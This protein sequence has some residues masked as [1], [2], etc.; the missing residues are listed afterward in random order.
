MSKGKPVIGW[1]QSVLLVLGLFSYALIKNFYFEP[2]E[3]QNNG[4]I[5]NLFKQKSQGKMV[6]VVGRVYKNLPDDN[7][8]SRHQRFLM[9]VDGFSILIA[10]NIDLAP[11]VPVNENEELSVYGEYVWNEK[12]GVIHWTH[13][14]PQNRHQGGWIEY[15]GKKFK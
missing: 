12:G 2:P 5:E 6:Q 10:H 13:H 8:G 11:R 9:D 14:D 7:K 3:R 15:K 1:K 4:Q